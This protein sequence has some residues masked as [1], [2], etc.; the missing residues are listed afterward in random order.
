M[1][2]S[3]YYG[4]LMLWNNIFSCLFRNFLSFYRN[5]AFDGLRRI[6]YKLFPLVLTFLD[7]SFLSEN[8]SQLFGCV[9]LRCLLQKTI[10]LLR[11]IFQ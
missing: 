9:L 5:Q 8:R 7:F 11:S 10:D 1:Q 6:V 2:I 3:G 4:S